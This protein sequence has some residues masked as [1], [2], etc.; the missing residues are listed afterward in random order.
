MS[1]PLPFLTFYE[2]IGFA[3]TRQRQSSAETHTAR[4]AF[5]YRTLGIPDIA[6][7]GSDVLEFGPGS[8]E[9]SEVLLALGPKSYKFVDGSDGVLTNLQSRLGRASSNGSEDPPPSPVH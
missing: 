9:N 8:G 5:L 4:R 2:D 6:A 3:P 7:R 1:T